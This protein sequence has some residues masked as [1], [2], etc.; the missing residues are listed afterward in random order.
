MDI[1]AIKAER[2]KWLGWKNI[3]PLYEAL[4]SLPEPVIKDIRFGSVVN[5]ELD[6]EY[7]SRYGKDIEAVAKMMKPWRKG[8]FKIGSLYIDSEWR[9]NLKYELLE[10]FFNLEGK[11]VADI[12]CNNGYYLFRMMEQKPASLTG[13]DPSALY[14]CQFLFLN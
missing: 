3:A 5:V 9:S 10:P 7:E 11:R 14:Y 6:S 8:P 2:Q 12:G 1:D 4:S 13:F